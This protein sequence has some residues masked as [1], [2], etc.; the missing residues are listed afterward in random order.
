MSK[1]WQAIVL[2]SAIAMRTRAET[3]TWN[4]RSTYG[5]TA[6]GIRHAIQDAKAHFVNKPND[7]LILEFDQGSYYLEDQTDSKGTIDL[8]GIQPG[9]AGRLELRGAGADRTTLVFSDNKTAIYGRKVYRVTISK[10][11]MTRKEYTVSQGL[12]VKVGR[13][14]VVLEIQEGFPSPEDIFNPKSD[15]GRFLRRYTNDPAQPEIVQEANEQLPWTRAL[16][17]EGRRWAIELKNKTLVANYQ[18][19]DLI[20]IK[21]KHGGQAYWF[22]EGSDFTFEDIK[23]TQKTRGVFRGGFDKIHFIRCVTDRSAPVNGQT[24]CLAAPGGGPQI[25]QPHDPPTTGNLI[26]D[27]R[28]I[29]SGD[30]AVA[31]F[32]ASGEI[33]DCYISDAFC[34]GILLANSP[35]AVLT[36]NVV[37]RCPVQRSEDYRMPGNQNKR[38]APLSEDGTEQPAARIQSKAAPSD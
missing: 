14:K 19:G 31:F 34:R 13:G 21:S 12:V 28:F 16:H 7:V 38:P 35:S 29:A 37:I 10:M 2:A 9:P 8:S 32:N 33:T 18:K 15:Q 20:G 11:H 1:Y 24:P 6:P 17:V 36:S 30:D 4:V 3:V 22:V 27:C 23:W 26:Q 5:I 25:G